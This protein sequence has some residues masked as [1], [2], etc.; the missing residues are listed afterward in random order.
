M[1]ADDVEALRRG[2]AAL[3]RGD[4]TGVRPLLHPEIEWQEGPGAPEAGVH[5]GRETFESFLGKWLESFDE[6]RI[7][8]EEIIEDGDRLIAVV[9]QTGRGRASGIEVEARIAH[10]WTVKDGRAIRWQS[11]STPEA[12]R[13]G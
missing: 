13:A 7:E 8:P 10:V 11:F 6:F 3:N 9:H 2:Y 12:A 5:Q 4:L 1:S